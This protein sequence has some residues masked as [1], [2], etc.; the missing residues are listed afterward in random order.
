M[1][2]RTND[3]EGNENVKKAIGLITKISTFHVHRA[4]LLILYIS[5][6]ALRDYEV[7]KPNL[8]FFI[9]STQATTKFPFPFLNLDMV[10][11]NSTLGRFT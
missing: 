8:T 5:L 3:G 11:R 6:P 1:I 9:G 10:L 7:R 2:L 4:F